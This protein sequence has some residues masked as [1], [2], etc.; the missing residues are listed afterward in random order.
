MDRWLE[1]NEVEGWDRFTMV[2]TGCGSSAEI[3]GTRVPVPRSRLTSGALRCHNCRTPVRADQMRPLAP[4]KPRGL[5]GRCG[6][7]RTWLLLE[8]AEDA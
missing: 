7:C 4:E 2:C 6:E 8:L 1:R 3:Q 5:V